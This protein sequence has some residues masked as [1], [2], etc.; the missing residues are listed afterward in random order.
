MPKFII[1][2]AMTC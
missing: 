2:A 1:V